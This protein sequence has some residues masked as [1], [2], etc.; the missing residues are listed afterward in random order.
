MRGS[1]QDPAAKPLLAVYDV[2]AWD[3][4]RSPR[5]NRPKAEQYAAGSPSAADLPPAQS[6]PGQ[7]SPLSR[8]PQKPSQHPSCKLGRRWNSLLAEEQ[9]R[10]TGS[11]P[12]TGSQGP[13]PPPWEEAF[14]LPPPPPRHPF[15]GSH[16]GTGRMW[17]RRQFL[18]PPC[19]I[20]QPRS[21]APSWDSLGARGLGE[22]W[23]C[24]SRVPLRRWGGGR[25]CLGHL[26]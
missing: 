17:G 13:F 12:R 4:G 5:S 22:P 6:D 7:V 9:M 16:E 19:C 8:T 11:P 21:S 20:P 23:S 14:S 15:P 10:G 2:M 1:C 25:A 26:K 3:S 24:G 18:R